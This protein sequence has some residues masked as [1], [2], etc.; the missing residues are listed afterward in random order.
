[1]SLRQ[2]ISALGKAEWTTWPHAY[3]CARD[4]PGHLAALLGDDEAAK[5][6]AARHFSS[7]I[8]HQSSVWPAS[9]DAFAWLVRVLREQPLPPEVLAE[10]VEALGEA[11]EYLG[12]MPTGTPVP[13]LSK[14]ARKWLKRFG[15]TPDDEHDLVWERFFETDVN[16]EVYDWVQ[17]R[18][19][20]LRPAVLSLADELA[21]RMPEA[22]DHLRE[23]WRT[24]K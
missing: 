9:P 5:T 19:V 13:E 20:A 16:Q 23:T 7:A 24:G 2:E 3:G 22:S 1:M 10:C 11:A 12:D 17:A 4:T 21:G 8:V 14:G 6:D 15:K 18:M